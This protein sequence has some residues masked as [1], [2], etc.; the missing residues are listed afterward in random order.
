MKH[1]SRCLKQVCGH[2][3]AFCNKFHPSSW[4]CNAD[5]MQIVWTTQFK[6][7]YKLALKRRLDIELSDNV[8]QSL[9]RGET[10]PERNKNHALTGGPGPVSAGR[11]SGP[12]PGHGVKGKNTQIDSDRIDSEK[13]TSGSADDGALH[14]SPPGKVPSVLQCWSIWG[15]QGSLTNRVPPPIMTEKVFFHASGRHSRFR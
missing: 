11:T 10:L 9:P 8:I 13:G 4:L 14:G 12:E 6:K 3:L 1:T 7:G 2:L 15:D 5:G